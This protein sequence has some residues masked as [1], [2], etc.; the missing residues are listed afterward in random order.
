[1]AD[2]KPMSEAKRAANK[3]WNDANLKDKYDRIQLVVPKGDKD[4]IKAAA[5]QAGESVSAYIVAAVRERMAR[6]GVCFGIST[7]G[8]S[9]K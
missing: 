6:E 8:D 7:P 9:D 2:K 5:D 4:V 1:M 3:K